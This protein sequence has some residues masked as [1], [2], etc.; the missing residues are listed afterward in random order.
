LTNHDSTSSGNIESGSADRALGLAS[1]ATLELAD[2]QVSTDPKVA[3][4]IKLADPAT[5]DSSHWSHCHQIDAQWTAGTLTIPARTQY[6]GF[7]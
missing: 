6:G 5:I 7:A 1:R 4:L 3:F 2:L